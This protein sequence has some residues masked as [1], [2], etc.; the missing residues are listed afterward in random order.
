MSD[1]A[2][3]LCTGAFSLSDQSEGIYEKGKSKEVGMIRRIVGLIAVA[4]LIAAIAVGRSTGN[5]PAAASPATWHTDVL[6]K[7]ARK[8]GG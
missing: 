1:R 5:P 7:A 3:G 6:P 4:G 8:P 2:T